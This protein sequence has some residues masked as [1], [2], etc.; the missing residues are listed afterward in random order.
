MKHSYSVFHS[1]VQWVLRNVYS[2]DVCV[3]LSLLLP[4][5]TYS[6]LSETQINVFVNSEPSHAHTRTDT[7]THANVRQRRNCVRTFVHWPLCTGTHTYKCTTAQ[8]HSH[9]HTLTHT[10]TNKHT[11]TC[12]NH[13]PFF[14]S[15][16][17]LSFL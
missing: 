6:R 9:M 10:N 5:L 17:S 7:H 14:L 2:Y 1:S 15:P 11:Y 16:L 13:V 4:L 12:T 8:T 3:L